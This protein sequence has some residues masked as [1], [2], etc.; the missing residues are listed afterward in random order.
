[1]QWGSEY[2]LLLEMQSEMGV[3]PK[4]LENQPTLNRRWEF[5][6][7]VFNELTGSRRYTSGGPANIPISEY[8]VYAK[9]YGFS[10]TEFTEYWE[11]LQVVDS[12]WLSELAKKREA[13]EKQAKKGK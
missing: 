2:S 3:T 12:V 8:K 6:K 10:Q 13:A 5:T 1:V 7:E 9:A 11:D 4:A